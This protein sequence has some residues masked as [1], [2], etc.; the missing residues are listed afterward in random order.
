MAEE[1]PKFDPRLREGIAYFEQMREA[2]PYDRTTLEFLAVAYE[3]I[4]EPE[5]R[6]LALIELASVLL[7]END[8]DAAEHIADRL[9]MYEEADAKAAAL[10]VRAMRVPAPSL[11]PE[12]APEEKPSDTVQAIREGIKAEIALAETLARGHI[13]DEKP[14]AQL[15]ASIGSLPESE[16]PFLVSAL[17]ALDREDPAA[18]QR[19][20]AFIADT[21]SAPPIPLEAFDPAPALVKKIDENL[22]RVRGAIPFAEL[23]DTLLVAILN[24]LDDALRR[25]V[26]KSAGRPCRFYLAAPGAVEALAER[27]YAPPSRD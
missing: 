10:K 17:A 21:A 27:I 22:A 18:A 14:A 20:A 4:G 11:V 13:I 3:Q 19:A 12:A 7:K 26:E 9:E 23:G 8:L 24:P 2:M 25:K 15:A 6:R 5:K 1:K 16:K